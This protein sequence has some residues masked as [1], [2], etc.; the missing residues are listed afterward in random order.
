MLPRGWPDWKTSDSVTLGLE[1]P[2]PPAPFPLGWTPAAT[3]PQTS[4]EL[5]AAR[6]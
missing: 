2:A 1:S 3:R 6:V 5:A 4:A